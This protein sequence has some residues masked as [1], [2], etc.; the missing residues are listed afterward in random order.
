[1]RENT[2]SAGVI[3]RGATLA[4]ATGVLRVPELAGML[5]EF[6]TMPA[7]GATFDTAPPSLSLAAEAVA[8]AGAE[9]LVSEV[10]L[11]HVRFFAL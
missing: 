7:R 3:G 4:A 1:M 9:T 6:A 10:A 5:C 8:D 11:H 2:A